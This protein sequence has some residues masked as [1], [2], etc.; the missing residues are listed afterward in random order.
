METLKKNRIV[1]QALNNTGKKKT[2][3]HGLHSTLDLTEELAYLA[4]ESFQ[5]YKRFV[6]L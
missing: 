3:L 1:V 6:K 5:R 4:H 2:S